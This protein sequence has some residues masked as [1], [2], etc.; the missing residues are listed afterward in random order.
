M[1]CDICTSLHFKP[2]R[3]L[4]PEHQQFISTS[5]SSDE[6]GYEDPHTGFFF[7]HRDVSNLRQSVDAKQCDLCPMVLS[8]VDSSQKPQEDLWG[9]N[10]NENSEEEEEHKNEEEPPAPARGDY[11]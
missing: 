4:S 9:N 7:H 6:Q 3:L 1:L 10:N 2:F 5:F 11:F 8:I